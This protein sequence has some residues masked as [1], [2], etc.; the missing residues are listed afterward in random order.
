M[1]HEAQHEAQ[2]LWPR[3]VVSPNAAG[4]GRVR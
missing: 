4:S 3:P 1:R 2:P